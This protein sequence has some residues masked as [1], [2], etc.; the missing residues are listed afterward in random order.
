MGTTKEAFFPLAAQAEFLKSAPLELKIALN[1]D[2]GPIACQSVRLN[3]FQ[4]KF[5]AQWEAQVNGDEV[6]LLRWP[7]GKRWAMP[8]VLTVERR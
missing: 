4:R 7:F 5:Y 6:K 2:G 1:F 8:M 3:G